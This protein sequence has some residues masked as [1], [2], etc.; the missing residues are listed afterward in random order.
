[1][2]NSGS[3]PRH[4]GQVTEA[5]DGDRPK[6]AHARA[7]QP[8]ITTS[9]GTF[10]SDSVLPVARTPSS[11]VERLQNRVEAIA[12]EIRVELPTTTATRRAAERIR[13]AQR[14]VNSSRTRLRRKMMEAAVHLGLESLGE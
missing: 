3:L 5:E 14:R 11:G 1:M 2:K 7:R 8:V 10:A 13:R 6:Q 12:A 9:P 4:C